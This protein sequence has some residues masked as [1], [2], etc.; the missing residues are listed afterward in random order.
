[1]T[2]RSM[3]DEQLA[4]LGRPSRIHLAVH[5]T[6]DPPIIAA[7]LE[8]LVAEQLGTTVER[9]LFHIASVGSVTGLVLED[10]RN[11]VVKAYQPR[12]TESFLRAV[13]Q[14]QAA[15]AEAGVPCAQPICEPVPFGAGLAT[16]EHHLPDPGQPSSFGPAEMRAS[17]EGLAHVID[18]LPEVT[19]LEHGP[20]NQPFRGL[21]PTPHSPLFDFDRTADGAEWIDEI[22]AEVR[23][24]LEA[25]RRV[26][27]HT[28]WAAR[29]VR[30]SSD[31]VTAVY[32]LDSLGVVPIGA[33]LGNA[34]VTWRSTGEAGDLEAPGVEEVRAWL[35]DFPDAL[36][37]EDRRHAFAHALFHLAYSS[38]CEHAI[39]PDG[40]VHRRARPTLRRESHLFLAVVSA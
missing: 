1:M 30:L 39:D 21:Y 13:A 26:A 34:A 10:G 14:G 29:N 7:Q 19:G 23:P 33:A 22:A 9:P 4:T 36:S 12:W 20:L 5:G 40:D 15:L 3:V 28:D 31:G 16:I 2:V 25:G 6:D 17:A 11:V 24:S 18:A 35:D 8:S 32:D 37:D 27:A 38:R